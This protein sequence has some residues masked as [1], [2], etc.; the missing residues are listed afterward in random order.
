MN[1]VV[2]L[3]L[4]LPQSQWARQLCSFSAQILSSYNSARKQHDSVVIPLLLPSLCLPSVTI[5]FQNICRLLTLVSTRTIRKI[6]LDPNP[7]FMSLVSYAA[8]IALQVM[9]DFVSRSSEKSRVQLRRRYRA[10]RYLCRPHI[11]PLLS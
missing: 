5:S 2:P 3:F 7:R 10:E 4:C 9:Y 11:K 8:A 1:H 6:S